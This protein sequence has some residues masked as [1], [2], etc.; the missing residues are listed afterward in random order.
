[1]SGKTAIGAAYGPVIVEG[2]GV[3][4]MES[5]PAVRGMDRRPPDP[6]MFVGRSPEL[7]QLEAAV[8]GCGR[9]VVVAVHGLGG[10]GK[11]TLTAR[12][13]ASQ[14]DRFS[15]VWWIVADSATAIDTGLADLA[16]AVAPETGVMPLEQCTELGVRWLATHTDWLLILDNLAGPADA[17]GLL[18]RVHTGTI[19]I[20]SRQGGGWR[21]M[22]TV[23]LDVL[24]AAQ[25]VELLIRIVRA[26]WPDAELTGADRLCAELGWL[27]LA[28]EQAGAY[29][30]QLRITPAAYL[31]L[32]ARFPARMFTAI[33]EGG[34]AQR[35]VARVWHVT[36]DRLAD[37]PLAG[38]L[39][40]QL[41]WYAPDG[42][43]RELL[44]G[45][46]DEP[47]VL[48]ALG[49]LA[50]Y[51]MITLTGDTIGVH[52][53]VQAVSRTPD[54]DDPHRQPDDVTTARDTAATTLT[55]AL[56]GQHHESPA[57]WPL[58]QLVLPHAQALIDH[59][60]PGRDTPTTCQLLNHFGTYL[61]GQGNVTTAI[62]YFTRT[63]RCLENLHGPDH[64]DTLTS[65]NNLASAYEWAG[66]LGRAVP[67]YE[68]T[69]TDCERVLG[70]DHPDTLTSRNN[71]A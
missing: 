21:G 33:A 20:T 59:T 30:G 29:L 27:P 70:P 69:L 26:E 19:V 34:D 15:L 8:A 71:L 57:S 54:P 3:P 43:P 51:N 16:V 68:A 65:R 41:A 38:Q 58:Y 1:M 9:A 45:T 36:L 42:I 55:T 23:A 22:Q 5:T 25:A 31:D 24:P 13:A 32:L 50:A 40:R 60:P 52:R 53:L 56:T 48:A 6:L 18:D 62:T 39:L 66:D 14:A 12:F 2:S 11:S 44:A 67:L 28:I 63:N 61:G 4:S 35:T 46:A 47:D 37:T 49:R 64:P 17:A 10:V 7:K